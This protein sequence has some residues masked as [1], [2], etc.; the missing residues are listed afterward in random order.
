MYHILYLL[1]NIYITSFN[2]H[3]NPTIANVIVTILQIKKPTFKD[4][5]LVQD[6]ITSDRQLSVSDFQ[7]P[8]VWLLSKE[9]KGR[10]GENK[11]RKSLKWNTSISNGSTS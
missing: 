10:E 5:W 7:K 2:H 1:S 9:M 3:T 11:R 6:H 8:G 4:K